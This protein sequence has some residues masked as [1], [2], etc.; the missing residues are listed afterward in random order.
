MTKTDTMN[1]K[2]TE[3]PAITPAIKTK[4]C[5]SMGSWILFIAVFSLGFTSDISSKIMA[6]RHVADEPVMVNRELLLTSPNWQPPP[7]DSVIV[8]P[9]ILNLRLV[10]NPGAVFGIGPGQRWFFVVFTI[11]A[12]GIGLVLFAVRT[13]AGDYISHIAIACILAGAAGNL[14]DR[15]LY[16]AVRDFLNML[17]DVK[18]PFGWHWPGGSPEVFPWVF[19]VADM[20]LLLGIGLLMIR[21]NQVDKQYRSEKKAGD[22]DN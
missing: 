18:M 20:L 15:L 16:G 3:I 1:N 9:N 5:F 11:I 8:I 6:F 2:L 14:Y 12:M 22:N 10:L 4:A 17:P 19:N 7:H 21:I 13:R